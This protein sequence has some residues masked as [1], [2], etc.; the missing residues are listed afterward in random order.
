MALAANSLPRADTIH[1]DARVLAFTATMSILVGILC[2][3]S[4]L[5]RMRIRTL[6]TALREGDLRTGSGGGATFGNGLVVAEIA[7]AF[8]LLVGAGLLVKNL[9]LLE[10][11]DAGIHTDNVIAFDLA[12]TGPRYKDPAAI[13]TLYRSLYERLAAIG[14]VQHVGLTSH[15]PMYR[16]GNNG[17]M[18]REGGNPWGA[19][20]NPSSSIDICMATI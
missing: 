5:I 12:P 4:P 19:N 7:I 15:L 3:L 17:E 9:M 10:R 11:R 1:I 20:E 6:T 2:G 13:S 18:T 8:A 14:G 16:F